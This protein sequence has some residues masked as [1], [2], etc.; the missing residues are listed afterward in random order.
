[1]VGILIG[2]SALATDDVEIN[3]GALV[4]EKGASDGNVVVGS[5]ELDP[6]EILVISCLFIVCGGFLVHKISL[7]IEYNF[8]LH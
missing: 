3:D 2:N 6:H 5:S 8:L 7:S 4:I 1:L